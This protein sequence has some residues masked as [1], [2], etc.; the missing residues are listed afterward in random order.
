[1]RLVVVLIVVV[2]IFVCWVFLD[3]CFSRG[4]CHRAVCVREGGKVAD[5]ALANQI[6][7]I[8]ITL[9][10]ATLTIIILFYVCVIH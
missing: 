7:D 10:I 1:M 3:L 6:A 5:V 9:A 4:H 8:V 2:V